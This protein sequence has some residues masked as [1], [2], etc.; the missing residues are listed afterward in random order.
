MR[1]SLRLPVSI[2]VPYIPAILVLQG[3]PTNTILNANW[4]SPINGQQKG[5][6]SFLL[7]LFF[8]FLVRI[9]ILEHV[10]NPIKRTKR[11]VKAERGNRICGEKITF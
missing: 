2:N 8:L 5:R 11:E 9:S 1:G 6:Q 7:L 10:V 4:F 3:N